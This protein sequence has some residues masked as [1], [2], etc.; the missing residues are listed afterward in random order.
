MAGS[1][2]EKLALNE[3]LFRVANERMSD[4][5]ERHGDSEIELYHCECSELECREKVSLAKGDYE[6][7]REDSAHF[8]V[9][10][11]HEKPTV[12]TVVESHEGW[13]M[14]EKDPEVQDLVEKTDPRAA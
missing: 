2:E 5:E 7:V 10:P 12:E 1:R 13:F 14:I 9:L 4:W 3:A 11:G 8:V 6:R